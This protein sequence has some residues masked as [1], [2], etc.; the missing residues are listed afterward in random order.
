MLN[1]SKESAQP[2]TISIY[3]VWT[4][5]AK[6]E[7]K[8]VNELNVSLGNIVFVIILFSISCICMS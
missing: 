8:P 6:G 5:T 4:E 2:G 1:G 3:R 7:V